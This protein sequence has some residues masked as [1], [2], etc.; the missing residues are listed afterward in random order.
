[1]AAEKCFPLRAEVFQKKCNLFHH[2]WCLSIQV[3]F[4]VDSHRPWTGSIPI[5]K[6]KL[7]GVVRSGD[8]DG[9]GMSLN[10]ET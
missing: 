7:S 2:G 5:K 10:L 8:R 4:L 6:K 3:M 1:M 9:H